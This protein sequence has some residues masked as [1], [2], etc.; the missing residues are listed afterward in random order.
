MNVTANN[1]TLSIPIFNGLYLTAAPGHEKTLEIAL[2]HVSAITEAMYRF[3]CSPLLSEFMDI[4]LSRFLREN[5]YRDKTQ[6][7][8]QARMQ[9]L[10]TLLTADNPDRRVAELGPADIQRMKDELP[11]LLQQNSTSASKGANLQAYYQLFN[12][13]IDEALEGKLITEPLKIQSCSTRIAQ[14]TK[15]F[16]DANLT[17]LLTG[18]PYK[19]YL[20]GT[21]IKVLQDA[22][23]Y[24]FWLIPLGLFTGARLNELCQLRVHD[25]FQDAHG[26]HL[27]NINANGFN[28][29][30]KTGHSAREIPI[31]SKLVEMG[32]LTFVEERLQAAGADAL[33]FEG[34]SYD[35]KHLHSR[36]ASRFFC[37]PVT[38]TGYIG[39]HCP[40]ALNGGFN[41]KSFRKTFALRLERSGISSSVI[42]YLLGH[43]GG[44]PQVTADHYLEKPLSLLLL[45]ELE[46]G[47]CYNLNL[48]GIQWQH[49]RELIAAQ[50]G[51]QKRGRSR[52]STL[53]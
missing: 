13:M 38:G 32:F 29:V 52:K 42:A 14:V 28:K 53:H 2:R 10:K 22:H 18:W 7:M 43:E 9:K 23:T 12:R 5:G 16:L 47:L 27:I 35:A 51:R 34:L 30:L 15:P 48:T 24:R 21:D 39:Q 17:S 50:G 31:C 40:I 37:G 11:R 41:F 19:P 1:K 45:E 6:H 36:D 49:F 25:V 33:L 20:S 46:R 26:V 3:H 8:L 44:A 4:V